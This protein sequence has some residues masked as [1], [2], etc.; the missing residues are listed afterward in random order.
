MVVAAETTEAADNDRQ[1][2]ADRDDR[3]S[4]DATYIH[5]ATQYRYANCIPTGKWVRI[6]SHQLRG[7]NPGQSTH[8]AGTVRMSRDAL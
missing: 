8:L 4:S 3:V 2:S 6:F 5:S 7:E 1:I